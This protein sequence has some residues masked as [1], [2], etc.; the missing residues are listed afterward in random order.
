MDLASSTGATEDKTM[1]NGIVLRVCL[2]SSVFMYHIAQ[3]ILY[4]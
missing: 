2:K 3:N 1:C 4:E